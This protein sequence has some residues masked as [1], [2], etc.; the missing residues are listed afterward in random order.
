ME[1]K[2]VGILFLVIAVLVGGFWHIQ[3]RKSPDRFTFVDRIQAFIETEF[4]NDYS[5]DEY[6][7]DYYDDDYGSYEEDY[8]DEDDAYEYYDSDDYEYDWLTP[9]E[10]LVY[11]LSSVYDRGEQDSS[12]DD[13]ME[14]LWYYHR[15]GDEWAYPNLFFLQYTSSPEQ[16]IS[17][18]VY[19]DAIWLH[20]YTDTLDALVGL[21][22]IAELIEPDW[23]G[24]LSEDGT[25]SVN[26]Q[27]LRADRGSDVV[28][29]VYN[30]E[31]DTETEVLMS[32]EALGIDLGFAE[33]FAVSNDGILYAREVFEGEGSFINGFWI[34]DT[35]TGE[36][37][38]LSSLDALDIVAHFDNTLNVEAGK[39][40]VATAE[41]G[42]NEFGPGVTFNPPSA[43]H[44]IDIETDT[45]QTILENDTFAYLFP[46]LSEDATAFAYQY[47]YNEDVWIAGIGENITNS[48]HRISGSLLDWV[49]NHIVVDRDGE[50]LV[51]N[52]LTE[53]LVSLDRSRGA[54]SDPDFQRIEYLGVIS[55]E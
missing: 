36:I 10:Y 21:D 41:Y 12:N 27:I 6:D 38:T 33:P 29:S 49:G 3:D 11:Q 19:G 7:F 54:Y 15:L 20:G 42:T 4:S 47:G 22:G 31:T 5:Y 14:Y 9:G 39:M 34:A 45:V 18:R 35:N 8:G 46:Q 30:L 28:A 23:K 43:L 52:L 37:K 26:Y 24:F 55:V 13:L 40:L 50:L 53:E 1:G 17:S 16:Y 25:Y 2:A 51:F 44:L 48:N 32:A